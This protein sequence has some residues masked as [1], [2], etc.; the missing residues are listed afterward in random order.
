MKLRIRG[1]SIRLRL[2]QTEV[3]VLAGGGVV[4][5]STRFAPGQRLVCALVPSLGAQTSS[6]SLRDGRLEVLVP[7]DRV[8]SWARSEEVSLSAEQPTG[9]ESL[10]SILIEKDFQCLS[11][12]GEDDAD[13]YPH[14]AAGA[15]KC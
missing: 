1:D 5:M 13:A 4:E 9:P 8:R 7:S 14:P 6:A 11:H 3:R 15:T 12:R 10:L 2:T